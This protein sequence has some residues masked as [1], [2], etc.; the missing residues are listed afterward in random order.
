MRDVATSIKRQKHM[1]VASKS[2]S[3][4]ATKQSEL[5]AIRWKCVDS[6]GRR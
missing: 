5:E 4:W 1:D 2:N 3:V 6:F